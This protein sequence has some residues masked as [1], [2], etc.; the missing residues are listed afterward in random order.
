MFALMAVAQTMIVVT[1]YHA[2]VENVQIHARKII[3]AKEPCV[4]HQI[5][6][7]FV[8]VPMASPVNRQSNVHNSNVK[9]M[10]IAIWIRNVSKDP[11]KIHVSSVAFA[12]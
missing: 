12:E 4:V 11:A 1:I 5:I 7:Q 8:Y 10:K 9:Q 6:V 2:L 3:A